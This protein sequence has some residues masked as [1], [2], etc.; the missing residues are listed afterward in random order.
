[1]PDGYSRDEL[2]APP[3]RR[4]L[5]RMDDEIRA[6]EIYTQP[7]MSSQDAVRAVMSEM[8]LSKP[9]AHALLNRAADRYYQDRKSRAALLYSKQTVMVERNIDLLQQAVE[10]G[11]LRMIGDILK[12]WERL[13]KLHGIDEKREDEKIVPNIVVLDGLSRFTTDAT[14]NAI[15]SD[16]PSVPD[17]IDGE[18]VE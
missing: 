9:Q 1:M 16:A 5:D 13:S 17:V 3:S 14:D 12:S 2:A 4:E 6:L 11:D 18:V 7:G 8:D 15:G 10:R